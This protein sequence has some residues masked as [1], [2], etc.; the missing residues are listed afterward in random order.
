[1][2]AQL[3]VQAGTE[4]EHPSLLL[5]SRNQRNSLLGFLISTVSAGGRPDLGWIIDLSKAMYL[6]YLLCGEWNLPLPIPLQLWEKERQGRCWSTDVSTGCLFPAA[7][8]S[9][10]I[11]FSLG[12][13]G[14][15]GYVGAIGACE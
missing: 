5:R 10:W 15:V 8:S 11:C 12:N 6:D 13:G 9:F 14:V 2:G 3:P 1:M 7:L 4:Q